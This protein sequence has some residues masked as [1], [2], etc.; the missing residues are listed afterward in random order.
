MG[1]HKQS[2]QMPF[3]HIPSL[4][5]IPVY[6]PTC[7]TAQT[8]KQLQTNTTHIAVEHNSFQYPTPWQPLSHSFAKNHNHTR[9][10]KLR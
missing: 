9:D 8:Q 4:S 5:A 10:V 7:N 3:W 1:W 6:S 2:S